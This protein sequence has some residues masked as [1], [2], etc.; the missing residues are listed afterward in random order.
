MPVE[1]IISSI[2]TFLIVVLVIGFLAKRIS[3]ANKVLA[4][5]K[6]MHIDDA[7]WK[8]K[9]NNK[10]IAYIVNQANSFQKIEN[11][12]NYYNNLAKWHADRVDAYK[13]KFNKPEAEL[14]QRLANKAK[15]QYHSLLKDSAEVCGLFKST[16]LKDKNC[17]I[18]KGELSFLPVLNDNSLCRLWNKPRGITSSGSAR[19]IFL[20]CFVIKQNGRDLQ[21]QEYKDLKLAESY[22]LERIKFE[23]T[24]ANDDEIAGEYWLHEKKKGGPDLRYS[25]NPKSYIVFRGVLTVK[26]YEVEALLK[27][28][29]RVKAH[30]AFSQLR[31]IINR[32]SSED[33]RQLYKKMLTCDSFVS[34]EELKLM[35]EEDK[36]KSESEVNMP[37]PFNESSGY[38]RV[39]ESNRDIQ[40]DSCV[41]Q[42]DEEANVL[43]KR[44]RQPKWDKYETALLI[45]G[46][47]KILNGE[48]RNKVVSSLSEKLRNIAELDGEIISDTFRNENGIAWQLTYIKK[49]FSGEGNTEK[50]PPQIFKEIVELYKNDRDSFDILLQI[51]HEKCGDIIKQPNLAEQGGLGKSATSVPVQDDGQSQVDFVGKIDYSHTKPEGIK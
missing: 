10:L 13:K 26:D 39:E 18:R 42:K 17:L 46:Y 25:Y 22:Q 38:N 19:F 49:A 51:A 28:S 14:E 35:I 45:E 16:I 41:V 15:E 4:I 32:L 24:L 23:K 44:E 8:T 48:S 36:K 12:I 30:K 31:G 9:Q 43:L 20:P 7:L 1:L 33:N 27:F 47:F 29:N 37:T 34:I 50:E 21:I 2:A 6:P 40:V 5:P 3:R 11:G